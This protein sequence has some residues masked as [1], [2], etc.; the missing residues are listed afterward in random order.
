MVDEELAM[1]PDLVVFLVVEGYIIDPIQLF[2]DIRV[3]SED[4]GS[5]IEP[6]GVVGCV[7][8]DDVFGEV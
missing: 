8:G 5:S 4:G 1:M 2:F 7:H 6:N 3:E